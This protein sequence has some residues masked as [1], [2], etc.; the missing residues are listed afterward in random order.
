MFRGII[1]RKC[2]KPRRK[3]CSP[4]MFIWYRQNKKN[5]EW[6]FEDRENHV[7]GEKESMEEKVREG[8]EAEEDRKKGGQGDVG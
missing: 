2:V 1:H 3:V 6:D 8:I 4:V 5:E 7:T